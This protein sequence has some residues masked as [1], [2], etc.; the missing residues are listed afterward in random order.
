MTCDRKEESERQCMD[1]AQCNV[2]VITDESCQ[3][4]SYCI[5]VINE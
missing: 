2:S 1:N 5:I 3:V 4:N